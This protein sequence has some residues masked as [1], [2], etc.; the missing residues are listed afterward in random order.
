MIVDIVVRAL[1][2]DDETL[3]S[4]MQDLIQ[5]IAAQF[6]KYVPRPVQLR[7]RYL[8]PLFIHRPLFQ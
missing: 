2:F 3:L 5:L 4:Q 6:G 1:L 7:R 8:W